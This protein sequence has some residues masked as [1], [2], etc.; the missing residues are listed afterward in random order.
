MDHRGLRAR[1]TGS[2][3]T[4]CGAAVPVDRIAVLADR[5]DIAF[6]ELDCPACG[7]RTMSVVVAADH[8]TARPVA[9]AHPGPG[10]GAHGRPATVILPAG[11]RALVEADVA[12][13]HRFLAGWEGDIRS[14]L[15]DDRPRRPRAPGSAR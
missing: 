3:C 1:L 15:A 13:M 12:D 11:A 9:T 5:G 4:S 10:A 7:S 2:G 8:G 14:L 6:V